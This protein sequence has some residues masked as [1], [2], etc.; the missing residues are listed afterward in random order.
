MMIVKVY[1]QHNSLV[2]SI[3][4]LAQRALGICAG[5][6]LL[7]DLDEKDHEFTA[8]KCQKGNIKDGK[9]FARQDRG[10]RD[11]KA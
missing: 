8:V 2:M 9:H 7:L 5:D 1:R 11:R 10:H 3:P 6:Y 4:V